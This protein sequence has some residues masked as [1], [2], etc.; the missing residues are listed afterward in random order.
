MKRKKYEVAGMME[1]HPVFKV[2]R[3]RLHVSFTGGHLCSGGNTPASYETSDP[4]VQT[5]IEKSAAFRSGKIRIGAVIESG[6]AENS[7]MSELRNEPAMSVGTY[8]A[9]TAPRNE[10]VME[11]EDIE[12]VYE[13]LQHQKGVPLERLCS[14]D[15]CVTEAK[16][17]GIVL[18]RKN[19]Q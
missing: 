15:S 4:V 6:K 5:V 10:F 14:P 8:T 3:T 9:V 19:A 2:G 17:L 13:F 18:K 16:R 1:W 12:E 11:Y 7:N